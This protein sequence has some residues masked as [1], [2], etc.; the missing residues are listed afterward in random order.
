MVTNKFDEAVNNFSTLRAEFPQ[1]A[2]TPDGTFK[3]A[4]LYFK[5]G[6]KARCKGLL[7]EL[8]ASNGGGN[9]TTRQAAEAFV[10]DNF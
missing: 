1:H 9:P 8:I 2:K 5:Q 10:R 7:D 3:L 4:T 6:N